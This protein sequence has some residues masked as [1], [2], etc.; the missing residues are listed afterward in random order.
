MGLFLFATEFRPMGAVEWCLSVGVKHPG[1]EV[2][3]SPPSSAEIKNV[4][5]YYST[6]A[7]GQIYLYIYTV[8]PD[9]ICYVT[10]ITAENGAIDTK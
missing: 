3:H 6:Y 4:W 5:S 8:L 7:Q 9:I 1:R 2:D 10:D